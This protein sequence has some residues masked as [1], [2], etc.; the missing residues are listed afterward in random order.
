MTVTSCN[1]QA[2]AMLVS[3]SRPGWTRWLLTSAKLPLAVWRKQVLRLITLWMSSRRRIWTL[4]ISTQ[5]GKNPYR[6]S[7]SS[8]SR[9][10]ATTAIVRRAISSL[11]ISRWITLAKIGRRR[12]KKERRIGKSTESSSA[13]YKSSSGRVNVLMKWWLQTK[14][15]WERELDQSF[16]SEQLPILLLIYF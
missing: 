1:M 6:V 15:P 3:Q 2:L 5:D 10:V 8:T 14:K 13:S 12:S 16:Q 7:S 9:N 11:R 4:S